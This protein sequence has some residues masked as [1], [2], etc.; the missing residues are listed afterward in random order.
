MSKILALILSANDA[1]ISQI[2]TMIEAG[3]LRALLTELMP[4]SEAI[5]YIPTKCKVHKEFVGAS[6]AL[7]FNA[8][9]TGETRV[10]VGT[11]NEWDI[12]AEGQ[13]A[14]CVY[15]IGKLN[16]WVSKNLVEVIK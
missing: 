9:L 11:S 6:V 16:L 3:E 13:K 2:K 10:T 12:F 7:Y 14:Y 5:R 15:S 4:P 8:Q 1:D